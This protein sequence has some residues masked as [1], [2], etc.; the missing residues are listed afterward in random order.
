MLKFL[1]LVL[2]IITAQ[3]V[4]T[5]FFIVLVIAIA[6]AASSGDQPKVAKNSVLHL[7]FDQPIVDRSTDNPLAGLD[8]ISG[9]GPE[10]TTSLFDVR[11][12]IRKA[13]DDDKIRGIFLDLNNVAVGGT[14]R[15]VL[16]DD[17]AAFKKSGKFIYAYAEN[18]DQASYQLAAVADSIFMMPMGILM[19]NGLASSPVFLQGMLEKLDIDV[20]LI[21]VGKYKSAGEPFIRKD[22]SADNR[23]QMESYM[24]DLYEDYLSQIS[25]HRGMPADSLRRMADRLDI[26]SDRDALDRGMVHA[27]WHRDEVLELL[28]RKTKAKNIEKIKMATLDEY[29]GSLEEEE[30]EAKDEIAVVYANGEISGGEGDD[31]NIGSERLSATLRKARLDKDI[32]AVVLRVNSPG[33]DALASEVI[34]RELVL[35]NKKKPIVVSMGNVAASGGY[36]IAAD[37]DSI[38]AEPTTITGSI[39]VFGLVPDFSGFFANKTGITFDRVVTGPYAD[40]MS[41]IRP[42]RADEEAIIQDGVNRVYDDFIKLVATGRR[43]STDSVQAMAQGRVY[44]GRQALALGLVDRMGTEEDALACASRLAKVK[45]YK[46]LRMPTPKDPFNEILKKW[47][48]DGA[49]KQIEE[50]LGVLY[51]PVKTASQALRSQGIIARMEFVPTY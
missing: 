18:Y 14:M 29:I 25:R 39:G 38:F 34:R 37:A 33:G 8:F 9:S 30:N 21:R 17:L 32:K 27:L 28:A 23:L 50:N 44:T 20:R 43:L 35:L 19:W 48:G 5:L 31:E 47:S 12:A 26:R 1:R 2:A 10:E 15:S 42:M 16:T 41:G 3:I 46:I 45:D 40:I 24:N 22:L 11:R 4:I 6:V 51:A 13:A 36:W 49:K 7:Q